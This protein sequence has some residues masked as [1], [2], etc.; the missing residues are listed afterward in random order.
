MSAVAAVGARRRLPRDRVR[1]RA[2][3]RR[4]GGALPAARRTARAPL[5]RDQRPHR[6]PPAPRAALPPAARRGAARP[7]RPGLGRRRVLRRRPARPPRRPRRLRPLV[8]EV[9]STP[10]EHDR[11]L[12]ELWIADARRR[13]H[14]R[15][16]QGASL[17]RRR[18]RRGRAHGAAA[19]R[20]ARARRPAAAAT[21]AGCRAR[22]PSARRARRRRRRQTRLGKALGL[23]RVPLGWLRDP[24][25]LLDAPRAGVAGGAG[26]RPHRAAARAAVEPQRRDDLD[27]PPRQASRA[28][29]RT[30]ASSSA[31]SARPSTTSS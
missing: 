19:R 12:W 25:S 30:C 21:A 3:A 24:R 2:D 18:A 5:R 22:V 13:P 17:P 27:A 10:L 23:A 6:R 16:R 7:R 11:A 15:R 20:D 14:R 9:M 26:R 29:S 31:A 8:D 1:A 28:R 4:L